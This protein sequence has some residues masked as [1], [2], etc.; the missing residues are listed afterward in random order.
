[1]SVYNLGS[2]NIYHLI[3]DV[4][5]IPREGF[6]QLDI[7]KARHGAGGG[8]TNRHTTHMDIATYRLNRYRSQGEKTIYVYH[9]AQLYGRSRQCGCPVGA[10]I[11]WEFP[12]NPLIN[13]L[14][15]HTFK[16]NF[17]FVI[18]WD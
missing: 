8:Q 7:H 16:I 11:E 3:F 1:M 4:V 14:F 6:D 5:P 17:L 12:S 15:Q 9:T 10:L 2:S 13:G 18:P